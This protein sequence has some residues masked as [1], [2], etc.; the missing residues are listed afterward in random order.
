LTK[1]HY[2]RA[3]GAIIVY[4]I[5]DRNSF[6]NVKTWAKNL[7]EYGG[8]QLYIVLVGNKNDLSKT[9]RQVTTEEGKI[10]AKSLGIDF[11]ET[12]AK[13]GENIQEMFNMLLSNCTV[14]VPKNDAHH[15]PAVVSLDR[16]QKTRR[17]KSP[18]EQC[19]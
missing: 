9:E 4:D 14:N 17:T 1:T 19:C 2:Q 16:K 13:T 10:L 7:E 12:T 6:E 18:Q 3:H 8:D 11:I 5:S 15:I